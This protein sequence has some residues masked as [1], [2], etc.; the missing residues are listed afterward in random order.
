[1]EFINRIIYILD[2]VQ[3]HFQYTSHTPETEE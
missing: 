3:P 2:K 1:M